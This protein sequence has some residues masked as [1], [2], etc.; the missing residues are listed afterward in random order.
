MNREFVDYLKAIGMSEILV[1]RVETLCDFCRK[2]CPDEIKD[3]LVTEFLKEDGVREYQ[4]LWFFT[5]RFVMEAK[6]FISLDD[7]D[8]ML[9][10][11]RVSYWQI[12][13]QDYDFETTT[14]KS[15]LYIA[16]S[17]ENMNIGCDFKASKENCEYLKRIFRKYIMS[18][19]AGL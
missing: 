7:I 18:N 11:K 13:K 9:L 4:S 8:M 3:I 5:E 1:K 12:K 16:V 17:V 2:N 15:R 10:H 14:D 19:L 6:N